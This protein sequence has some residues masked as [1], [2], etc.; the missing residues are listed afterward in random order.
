MSEWT[1]ITTLMTKL[2]K[3]KIQ[4]I[5]KIIESGVRERIFHYRGDDKIYKSTHDSAMLKIL[6]QGGIFNFLC[7]MLI[8]TQKHFVSMSFVFYLNIAR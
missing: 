4:D 8:E 6:F 2:T 7:K 1:K 3:M 5:K